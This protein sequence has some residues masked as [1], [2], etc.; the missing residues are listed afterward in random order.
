LA[1]RITDEQKEM[2]NE[3]F[4][5]YG[6]KK[7][8][9]EIIGCSPSTVSKYIIPN[10]ISKKE[11]KTYTFEGYVGNSE[12]LIDIFKML[13]DPG[14]RLCELCMLGENEWEE[15]RQLQTEIYL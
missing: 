3:L 7:K 15:I 14:T 6:V 8:V 4:L 12:W 5:E 9:A 11:C 10:Y 2:I 13:D 1:K